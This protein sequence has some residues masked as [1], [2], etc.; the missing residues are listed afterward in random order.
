MTRAAILVCPVM[1]AASAVWIPTAVASAGPGAIVGLVQADSTRLP[2][3]GAEVVVRRAADS[4]V[5][6]HTLV[7][8][9]GRFRLE[10]LPL[11]RY[12]VRASLLGYRPWSSGPV[13]LTAASPV[14]DL[15]LVLLVVGAIPLEGITVTTA[16]PE[17]IVA[18]DR[19]IYT[20]KDMPAAKTGTTTDLLRAVPELE[21][22][23][24]GN[25]SLRGSS[26]VT[27]QFNSRA[28]P[29][30]GSGLTAYLRQLP[31]NRVERIEVIANPSARY[32]PEGTAGIVNIVLK[33]NV[34]LGL[35]GS[36]S[37]NGGTQYS[38]SSVRVAYQR[39]KYTLFGG[40]S[41]NLNRFRSSQDVLR[42]NLLA[43]P[44]SS[45]GQHW[46]YNSHGGTV[47]PDASL[48]V[49]LDKV[50]TVYTSYHAY[51]NSSDLRY[52]TD[53]AL[54]DPTP[55]PSA[56]YDRA[57]TGNPNWHNGATTVGF[58]HVTKADK[59][60]WTVE[61]RQNDNGN[62]ADLH[63]LEHV[64]LPAGTPDQRSVS[65]GGSGTRDRSLQFDGTQPLG[66]HGKTEFGYRGSDRR[67]TN[68]SVLEFFDGDSVV[69]TPQSATSEYAHHE[70][71]QSG[72]L[73][74]GSTFGKLSLQ[75]GVRGEAA[76][77]TFDVVTLRTHYDND[78]R[79][80]FPSAN[81]AYDLGKGKNVRFTY[82]KRIDRPSAGYLN[83]DVPA[84]DSL[85]RSFG[86]PYLKPKYTHSLSLQASWLGSRGTVLLAPF[87]RQTVNNWDSFKQV[88]AQGVSLT[89]WRNAASVS[90][91]GAN[92][93]L[94]LR[95]TGRLGGSLT[96]GGNE[97]RHDASNL[98]SG[99]RSGAFRWSANGYMTVKATKTIDVQASMRYNPPELLA[100]G[101]RSSQ[102]FTSLG[103][104]YKPRP[105]L[106]LSLWVNDPFNQW[107]SRSRQGDPSYVQTSSFRYEARTVT[108]GLTWTFGKPP[109]QKQRRSNEEQAQPTPDTQPR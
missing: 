10:G 57:S 48:E 61:L 109:E 95:Q 84:I 15:G 60:E 46:D 81:L 19:N 87:Y 9:D 2:L 83:P 42:D 31:A 108:L 36:V 86:N 98:E 30:T 24:D 3:P 107:H 50:S 63:S 26:N 13:V 4:T 44:T 22:D 65:G 77:T 101:E 79:S 97:D 56:L 104:S 59:N 41:G 33:D 7:A 35:S 82:S 94:S 45:L 93:T 51:F 34:D 70:V 58:R 67:S 68:S 20:T 18:P 47:L 38:G 62:S 106:W 29:M 55:T 21:V 37:V 96:L 32:D 64:S 52:D 92:L 99:A 66:G 17:M 80:V 27:I 72:Y 43:Q 14:A 89:T 40:L 71:F 25:V 73:T 78:Y 103:A 69:I 105:Q 75:L 88:D 1:V 12:L 28:A 5:V 91:Y 8:E 85:N 6:A 39:G 76:H 16:R 11:D 74:A 54:L 100:Q 90:T 53:Y 23:M 49:A 102:T